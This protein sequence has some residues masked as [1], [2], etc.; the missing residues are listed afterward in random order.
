[1]KTLFDYT[2]ALILLVPACFVILLLLLVSSLDTRKIG[3]FTQKRIGQ[4][5]KPFLIYKIRT[6]APETKVPTKIG[7][8]LR[9][10]K[11]DELPQLFNI[12]KGEMS[13]VGPRPDIG[14]YYD[15]LE[16]EDRNILELKPGL[17]SLAAIKYRKEEQILAKESNPKQYNDQIIFPDKVRMNL[18]YYY[19]QS[20]IL[21]CIIILKTIFIR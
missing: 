10:S 4:F 2:L 14:G 5:G 13:F 1:M 20:L 8:F 19:N 11:L 16:G 6:I 15:K 7:T 9:Q 17:T 18:D 12:L 21:D 3:F